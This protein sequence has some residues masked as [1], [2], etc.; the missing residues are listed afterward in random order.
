MEEAINWASIVSAW[1]GPLLTALGTVI[2]GAILWGIQLNFAMLRHTSQITSIQK[3]I[4]NHEVQAASHYNQISKTA[5]LLDNI[6][7]RLEKL[8][9]QFNH[10][11]ESAENW[12]HRVVALETKIKG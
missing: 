6:E 7:Q 3:Q 10:H 11:T 9:N 1:G 5:I 4:S 8:D 2:V 12:R